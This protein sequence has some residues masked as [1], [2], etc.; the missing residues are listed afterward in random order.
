MI[1][2]NKSCQ[3]LERGYWYVGRY[4]RQLWKHLGWVPGQSVG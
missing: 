2:Y 4:G 1:R 3:L